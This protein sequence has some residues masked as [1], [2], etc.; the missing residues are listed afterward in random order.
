MNKIINQYLVFG[1]YKTILN[2]ILIFICLGI[3]LNLFE[4][5][6]FFKNLNESIA[7]PIKLTFLYIPNLIVKLFPFIIFIS[8]MWFLLSIR[9]NKDLLSLKVFGYSNI[10][11]ILILSFAAFFLGLVTIF[12]INPV[13]SVMIKTYEKT[14]AKYAD[15]IDHLALINKN[16]VWIKEI[17]NRDIR[18]ITAES[19]VENYLKDVTIYEIKNKNIISK[20]IEAKIV[21]ISNKKWNLTEVVI[22]DFE[23]KNDDKKLIKLDSYQIESIYNLEKLQSLYKNL[24]TVSFLELINEY[25]YLNNKGYSFDVLNEKINIFLSIPVFLFLMVVLASIFTIGSVKNS[26]NLYYIFISIIA[27]VVI[28]YFKD[29][30]IAL[31]QTNRISLTLAVWMPIVAIALYCSIGIL[32]INEN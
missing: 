16:G 17:F 29:L 30:S 25:E 20:R 14:K 10:R 12:A 13:T 8:A 26:Q 21:D 28:Y 22:F 5:I 7:L 4:E 31:G 15:D 18:I 27:C 6:E 19:L 23:D 9:S 32:Q 2:V 24:D 11:I 1:F 3:I